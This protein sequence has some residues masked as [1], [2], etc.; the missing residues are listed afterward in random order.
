MLKRSDEPLHELT[1][2]Q[3][4][5]EERIGGTIAKCLIRLPKPIVQIVTLVTQLHA[6]RFIRGNT[7]GIGKNVVDGE[8]IRIRSLKEGR[9][10]ASERRFLGWHVSLQ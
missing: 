7:V 8:R 4:A 6:E 5:V 1:L 10:S 2:L 3:S 9:E